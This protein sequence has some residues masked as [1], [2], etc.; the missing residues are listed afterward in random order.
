MSW[1]TNFL[2]SNIGLKV[3]MA[4]TGFMLVGF[5]CGHMVGNLQVFLGPEVYNHYAATLQGL[6]ELLWV[7]RLVLL[8]AVVLHIYSATVLTLR[9]WSARPRNY[10]RRTW[11]NEDYAAR[12]MKYGGVL[13][14]V[15]I[16]YHLLQFTVGVH[17]IAPEGFAHCEKNQFGNL[18]C[19]AFANLVTG[20]Q[21]IWV[22]LFYMVA[23]VGV[24]LHLAHGAWSM[25]RTLGLDSPRYDRIVRTLAV[26]GAGVVTVGFWAVPL[27]VLFK[28]VHL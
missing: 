10:E 3:V 27:S 28:F 18:E 22:S 20:F 25:F 5:V 16:V 2:N 23:M 6:G 1:L 9:S 8:T 12:T 11:L 24:G 13:V 21:N 4:L 14:A 19:S 7:I 26:V 17:G 15:F